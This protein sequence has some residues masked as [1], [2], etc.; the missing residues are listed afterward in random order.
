VIIKENK[1]SSPP[2]F[3]PALGY[4]L[5]TYF[6][7]ITTM[8]LMPNRFRHQLVEQLSPRENELI[9]DFGIGTAETAILIK[10]INSTAMVVGTDI[11]KYILRIAK[12][13][14]EK[15]K[16]EILLYHNGTKSLPFQ[17][18]YFDKVV[19]CLVFCNL[20]PLEKLEYLHEIKRTMKT[21]GGIYVADWGYERNK[22]KRLAFQ[23]I[24]SFTPLISSIDKLKR[25]L[26]YF[27]EEAGFTHIL[28]VNSVKTVTGTLCYYQAIK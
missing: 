22:F 16:F 25:P 21:G 18:D 17:S 24:M 2:T 27:L 19:S 4:N 13:K 28:E 11:D 10:R 15:S 6:Y 23:T 8:L 12:R 7:D 5:L 20:K 26:S 9:L 14:I 1:T 3:I